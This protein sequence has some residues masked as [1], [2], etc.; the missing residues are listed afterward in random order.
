MHLAQG[1][2]DGAIPEESQLVGSSVLPVMVLLDFYEEKGLSFDLVQDSQKERLFFS[3]L[4]VEMVRRRKLDP[5]KKVMKA[6][7]DEVAVE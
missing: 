1:I 6:K 7:K 3:P 2:H 4:A 5:W